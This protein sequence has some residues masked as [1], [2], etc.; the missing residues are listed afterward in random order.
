MDRIGPYIDALAATRLGLRDPSSVEAEYDP[1]ADGFAA[2]AAAYADLLGERGLV[3]FDHQIIRAIEVLLADPHARLAARRV[4]SVML[5]DEFQDLTP[6]HLLL[7]RLLAGPRADVFAVGDDDQTIYGY[8]GASPRWLI[9]YDQY[10]PRAARHDLHVNYRCPPEV[11][12]AAV[13]LLSHNADRLDKRIAAR[14]GLEQRPRNSPDGPA[15][16]A[17]TAEDPALQVRPHIERLLGRGAQPGDIAVLSRVNSTLLAPQLALADMG[18]PSDRPVGP[19]FLSRNG[20][21]AALAWVEAATAADRVGPD[22]MEIIARRPRGASRPIWSEWRPSSA[23]RNSSASWPNISTTPKRP[24]R[25]TSWPATSPPSATSPPDPPPQP[26]GCSKRSATTSAWAKRSKN[27]STLPATQRTAHHT[28]TTFAPSSP[29]PAYTPGPP[30][31]PTGSRNI[32]QNRPR[33]H[34]EGCGW[35]PYTRSKGSNGPM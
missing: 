15:I 13:S 30:G 25:S 14:P 20:V 32:S 1:D 23:Q 4:C 18:V 21:A 9:D 7:V 5:V 27:G 8:S 3:D 17:K 10:F 35:Q 29:S 33:T 31:S 26:P 22:T 34:R 19:P 28:A 6:A 12:D 24:T 11:V 16:R 2:V